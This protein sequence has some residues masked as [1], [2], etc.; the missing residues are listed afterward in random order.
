MIELLLPIVLKALAPKA[1]AWV[2]GL[3]L[4]AVPAVFEIVETLGETDLEGSDKLRL[5]IDEVGEALDEALDGVPAWADI[6]EKRRDVILRGL[7]ELIVFIA[8][9]AGGAKAPRKTRKDFRKLW[10][11]AAKKLG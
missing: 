8:I 5:A 11:D 6:G 1:P 7:V 10:K 2:A 4:D 3:I 9:D